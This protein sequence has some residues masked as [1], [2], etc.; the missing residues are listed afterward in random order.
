[1]LE[2]QC[3]LLIC[4]RYVAYYDHSVLKE[5]VQKIL[6]K[7]LTNR[8]KIQPQKLYVNGNPETQIYQL[9][10]IQN[11]VLNI[12]F[13]KYKHDDMIELLNKKYYF[14]PLP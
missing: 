4:I 5:S 12:I 8:A 2:V 11:Y 13:S 14:P 9:K 6:S 7:G 1:M 10:T 3:Q